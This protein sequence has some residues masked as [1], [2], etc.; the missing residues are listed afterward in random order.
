MLVACS[1]WS[2]P[3]NLPLPLLGI[4]NAKVLESDDMDLPWSHELSYKVQA[5]VPP[6]L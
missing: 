2:F 6:E 3:L 5:P 4:F 1:L